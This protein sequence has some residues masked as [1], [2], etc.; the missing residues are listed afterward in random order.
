RELCILCAINSL[1]PV[2]QDRE[3][4][5]DWHA[6]CQQ[7]ADGPNDASW[8][9]VPPGI[10]LLANNKDTRMMPSQCRRQIVQV[11]E[12]VMVA[13]QQYTILLNRVREL[14][15]IILS[16]HARLG[17]RLHVVASRPQEL[18]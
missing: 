6:C 15:G 1:A 9:Q 10:V 12:I 7:L 3:L 2:I 18:D 13:G 5:R 11:S 14:H 8:G 4:I 16:Y 17:G